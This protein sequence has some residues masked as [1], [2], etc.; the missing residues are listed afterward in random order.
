MSEGKR[1]GI[2][3]VGNGTKVKTRDGTMW[4]GDRYRRNGRGNE[5]VGERMN[6]GKKERVRE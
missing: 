5:R 2:R 1:R 4:E 3:G 6:D